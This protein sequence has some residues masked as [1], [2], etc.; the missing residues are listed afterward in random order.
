MNTF[1]RSAAALLVALLPLSPAAF[2][3]DRHHGDGPR[4]GTR[5]EQ[6]AGYGHHNHY[7]AHRHYGHRHHYR[8]HRYDRDGYG[9]GY[10]HR[11]DRT[12]RIVV[13]LPPVILPPHVVLHR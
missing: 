3:S 8:W 4:H 2:A 7:R 13:P 11:H 1:T 12:A 9:Y 10:G 5:Y 6:H